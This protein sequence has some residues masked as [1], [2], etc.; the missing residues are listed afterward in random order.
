[1]C[2]GRPPPVF[3]SRC[4]EEER[5]GESAPAGRPLCTPVRDCL[6]PSN[7]RNGDPAV[8][9]RAIGQ[10]PT[11]GP[12]GSADARGGDPGTPGGGNRARDAQLPACVRSGLDEGDWSLSVS[13]KNDHFRYV[14]DC[15]RSIWRSRQ[16]HVAPLVS[17]SEYLHPDR[18][19]HIFMWCSHHDTLF[20][21]LSASAGVRLASRMHWLARTVAFT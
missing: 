3:R 17:N 16:Q 5:R 2:R 11:L 13:P 19:V 14:C 18:F 1:M 8:I 15:Q 7:A 6:A 20:K 21:Y 9:E 10:P 12:L 4:G